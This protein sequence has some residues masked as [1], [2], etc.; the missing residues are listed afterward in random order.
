MNEKL[1]LL[2]RFFN[3]KYSRND[4]FRLKKLILD[5]DP[6]FEELMHEHWKEFSPEKIKQKKDLSEITAIINHELDKKSKT[7]STLQKLVKTW[8]RVAAIL[9]IP[10]MLALA[11]FYSQFEQYLGQKGVYVEVRSPAGARTTLNLPDGSSVWLNGNSQIRYPVVFNENRHVQLKGEAFFQVHSDQEHPFLVEANKIL[12]KATGTEFDVL[13]Y[14]ED[15]EV[16]VILKEGKV[17]VLDASQSL[18]K[19]MEAGYQLKYDKQ[20]F[21]IN[22]RQI[23]AKNY[24]G[25]IHGRLIFENASMSEVI[26]RMERWYGVNIE[27]TDKEL[28]QLH[29]KATFTNESIEEALKLLQ[30]TAT[31]NYRFIKRKIRNDGS[32][33]DSKIYIMKRKEQ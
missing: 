3:S 21:A 13:A 28:L 24:S 11:F 4:Y 9:V 15:P 25:W 19:N 33:E 31:F 10:L 16:S 32:F 20:T 14:E 12:V 17:A 6:E 30:S 8:S 5:H 7:R 23:N 22:Y 2:L 1:N 29:F 18:L 27:V 26:N